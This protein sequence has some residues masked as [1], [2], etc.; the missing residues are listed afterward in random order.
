MG[1]SPIPPRIGVYDFNNYLLVNDN[2]RNV[3]AENI[4]L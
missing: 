3:N 2:S 1:R 4:V